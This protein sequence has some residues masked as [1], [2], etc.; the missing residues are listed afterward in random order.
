MIPDPKDLPIPGEATTFGD[1]HIH[2][3]FLFSA[4]GSSGLLADLDRP[5][6]V[7]YTKETART[8]KRL[9]NGTMNRVGSIKA[10][11]W[12]VVEYVEPLPS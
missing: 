1:L 4:Y 9:D 3:P 6:R 8:Y 5:G 7:V 12:P 11:C 10:K 2:Q